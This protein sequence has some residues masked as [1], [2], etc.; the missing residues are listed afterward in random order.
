MLD[1]AINHVTKLAQSINNCAI[2][3]ISSYLQAHKIFENFCQNMIKIF[4]IY[5]NEIYSYRLSEFPWG[6]NTLEII[7][8]HIFMTNNPIVYKLPEFSK[9][10]KNVTN[11]NLDQV[12]III[13][14]IDLINICSR[15]SKSALLTYSN[16]LEIPNVVDLMFYRIHTIISGPESDNFVLNKYTYESKKKL[17]DIR[18]IS[19]YLSYYNIDYIF[20][21]YYLKYLQIRLTETEINKYRLKMEYDLIS[22]FTGK[23]QSKKTRIKDILVGVNRWTHISKNATFNETKI[24]VILVN[25]NWIL[26][27][28]PINKITPTN[29]IKKIIDSIY[30]SY[31][32]K[33]NALIWNYTMGYVNLTTTLSGK[34]IHITCYMDQAIILD[35]F[36]THKYATI[37]SIVEKTNMLKSVIRK[38]IACLV[39]TELIIKDPLSK[40]V[41]YIPN[42][43]NYL[44]QT[45]INT[46]K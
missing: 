36:N 11:I 19:R 24:N 25:N 28:H 5:Q 3:S 1:I 23:K 40:Y 31:T 34:D 42:T 46:T 4:D 21:F 18:L 8:F 14:D 37:K 29:Q 12:L 30:R 17:A 33:S 6:Y 43:N 15:M 44:G 20:I 2:E 27:K 22:Y 16:I 39:E 35:Y 32:Y 7:F 9:L 41:K 10:I 38:A 13:H 45:I 26:A